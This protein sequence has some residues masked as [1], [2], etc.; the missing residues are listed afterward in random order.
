[1]P[2]RFLLD[3]HL[4]G[5]ALWRAIQKHNSLGSYPVDVVRVGDSPNLPLGS[6]DSDI[7]LWAEKQGFLLVSQD[8]RTLA[9]NL[10]NHLQAGHHIPG[11]FIIRTR[12]T[13]A[14]VIPFL[15][16]AAHASEI[17]DWQ[18]RVWFIP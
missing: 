6:S 10:A 8:K 12:S 4:R 1:M 7:L 13:V 16:A 18:D 5:G 9:A 11:I 14:Q 17:I 3:E 15:A 2:L